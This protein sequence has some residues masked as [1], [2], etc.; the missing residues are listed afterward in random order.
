MFFVALFFDLI[1]IVPILNLLTEILAGAI[2]WFWQKSYAPKVDPLLSLMVNKI[3]DFASLG[4]FPSNISMVIVAYVK[5][6]SSEKEPA[7]AETTPEPA[8]A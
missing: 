3:I 2:I 6:K 4:L 1:G 5:K 8:A 7:Q